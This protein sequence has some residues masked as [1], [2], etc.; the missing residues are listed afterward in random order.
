MSGFQKTMKYIAI[1]FAVF[2]A[3]MI[4]AG[5]ANLTFAIA[6]A[7]T[8]DGIGDNDGKTID[9]TDTFT[10]VD[11]LDIENSTGKLIIKQ[12]NELRIEAENVNEGFKA[13]VNDGTLT[14]SDDDS[15]YE[16]FWFHF[17]GFNNPNSKITI[18]LPEDFIADEAYIDSGAGTVSI[19]GLF[20]KTLVVSAGAGAVDGNHLYAEDVT[21]D[22]GVGA[23]TLKDVSF[24]DAEL[25][26]GV[27][28]L[29]ITGEL[30]GDTNIDC[31]IGG[32]TLEL[33]GNVDD[34][35]LDVD[36]GIGT[37]K[38]N[39]KKISDDYKTDRNAP[40]YIQIE[41]GIGD[42]RINIKE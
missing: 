2:L 42:V 33:I 24:Y 36:S 39:G 16:F 27:G 6:S 4:V 10:G 20:A 3:V 28:P 30:T 17:N 32:V 12:G 23:V 9:F 8:G 15:R 1:A 21:F 11:R 34:Y 5:I 7:V 13:E 25:N 29:M 18:Y 26:C 14:I 35:D 19:D 31:G 37:I 22:G 40:N 41:G 38:L